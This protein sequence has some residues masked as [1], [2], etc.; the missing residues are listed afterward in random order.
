MKSVICYLLFYSGAFALWRYLNRNKIII[1]MVHGVGDVTPL[2]LWSPL[3]KRH[4]VKQLDSALAI[5]SKKYS[6]ISMDDADAMLRGDIPIQPYSIVMTF[7]DGYR[8]SVTRAMPI[9]RKY[10]APGIIYLA[11]DYIEHREAYWIDRIDYALQKAAA[12]GKTIEVKGQNIDLTDLSHD[13]KSA[14]YKKLRLLF[15]STNNDNVFTDEMNQLALYL[16]EQAGCSLNDV[17]ESDEWGRLLTWDEVKRY[18]LEPDILFGSHTVGHFRLALIDKDQ[19]ERELLE[20]KLVLTEK[21]GQE[22]RHFCYPAGSHNT[23][24]SMSVTAAGYAS[25]VTCDEGLNSVG[26]NMSVLARYNF[27]TASSVP[28]ILADTSGLYQVVSGLKK[29]IRK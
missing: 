7:D 25:G 29:C 2:S 10:S 1:L 27:T 24:V 9:L 20:S 21:I 15:K 26:A 17:F 8:D 14:V 3:W 6:F 11:T 5:L 22:C 19:A 13:Q 18:S 16:E 4:S 12:A 28:Q 23:S